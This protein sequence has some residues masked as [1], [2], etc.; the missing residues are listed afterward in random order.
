MN[1]G[2]QRTQSADRADVQDLAGSLTHPLLKDRLG[3]VEKPINIRINDAI[4]CPLGHGYKT[5]A[6]IDRRVV[7]QNIDATEFVNYLVYH[8]ADAES[9]RHRNHVTQRASAVTH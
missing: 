1:A 6:A 8:L 5:V 9:I 4:P 2:R 7:D 3:D